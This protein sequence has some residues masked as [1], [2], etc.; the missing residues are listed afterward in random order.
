LY[1]H[2]LKHFIKNIDLLKKEEITPKNE[3]KFIS[4][5]EN[6]IMLDKEYC[7]V[8]LKHYK[9]KKIGLRWR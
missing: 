8:D 9:E 1:N 3:F 5:E 2:T 4:D 6:K 7:L